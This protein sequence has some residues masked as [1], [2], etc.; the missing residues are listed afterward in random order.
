MFRNV[1]RRRNPGSAR[2]PARRSYR[3]RVN[4]TLTVKNALSLTSTAGVTLTGGGT[5]SLSG[6]LTHSGIGTL[7][8][9]STVLS[10]ASTG[11]YNLAADAKISGSGE[12]INSG[13]LEKTGKTGSSLIDSGITLDNSNRLE[14]HSG[15]LTVS[16][17]VTQISGG[18]LT[19]GSWS[20]F[21]GSNVAASLS[22]S[23]ASFATIGLGA[24]VTLSGVNSSLANLS[25]VTLNQGSFS[26][27]GGQSYMTGGSF[28]NSGSLTLSPGSVL[29]ANGNLTQT[30]SGKVTIQISGTSG[31]TGKLAC[32]SSGKVSLGGSLIL[33]LTGTPPIGAIFEILNNQ[34]ASAISGIFAG[35][36][37]GSTITVNGMKF[38][39]SY[40]GGTGND[41]TLTRTA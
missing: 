28:T 9:A 11:V 25:A 26:L 33:T 19:A 17:P 8:I 37:E 15:T 12:I 14:V 41:V 10:I 21:G 38:K 13:L 16:G 27:L 7:Q 20:V 30:S 18:L 23:S 35:L 3:P 5:L 34:G 2:R 36:P 31:L 6:T 4:S 32:T 1:F 39:I 40:K 22:I 29:A 24:S